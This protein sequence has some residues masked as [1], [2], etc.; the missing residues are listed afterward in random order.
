MNTIGI[1]RRKGPR[2]QQDERQVVVFT[3]QHGREWIATVEIWTMHPV[4]EPRPNGWTAP[5]LPPPQYFRYSTTRHGVCRIDYD[6]WLEDLRQLH[7]AW[8]SD[9]LELMRR[10][11]L[12]REEAE[13]EVGRKPLDPRLVMAMQAG[14]K[15][16]LGI[17]RGRDA[18]GRPIYYPQPPWA[19]G[20]LPEPRKEVVLEFPD[21]EAEEFEDLEDFED[22]VLAPQGKARGGRRQRG[23]KKSPAEDEANEVALAAAGAEV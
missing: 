20:L 17:P 4:D 2:D 21:I 18:A 22:P 13:A 5:V 1:K 7:A 9:V 11:K 15:W 12:P 19:E 14:N 8:E 10:L 16:I 23:G 3:D 6:A